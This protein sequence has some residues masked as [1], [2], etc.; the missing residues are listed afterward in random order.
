MNRIS[1]GQRG[2]TMIEYALLIALISMTCYAATSRM[3][4]KAQQPLLQA[5]NGGGTTTTIP[6]GGDDDSDIIEDGNTGG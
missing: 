4:E 6:A 5:A 1:K 2:N 3:G